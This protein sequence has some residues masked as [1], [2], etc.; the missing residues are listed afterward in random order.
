MVR[1]L[2]RIELGTRSAAGRMITPN[3]PPTAPEWTPAPHP[4]DLI[5]AIAA[6][7]AQ[8]RADVRDVFL[9]ERFELGE[10]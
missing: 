5:E 7:A 10:N 3:E 8:R 9:P 2:V 6:R 1:P 4:C